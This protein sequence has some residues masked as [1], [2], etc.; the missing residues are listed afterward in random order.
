MG[1]QDLWESWEPPYD[2]I[3]AIS[4]PVRHPTAPYP[5]LVRDTEYEDDLGLWE[6]PAE[7]GP[8]GGPHYPDYPGPRRRAQHA[9]NPGRPRLNGAFLALAGA[10]AIA[11]AIP[12]GI[13]GVRTLA[14]HGNPALKTAPLSASHAAASAPGPNGGGTF[15][16]LAGP[17]CPVAANA[18]TFPYHAPNGDGWHAGTGAGSGPCGSSFIYSY[19]AMVPGNPGEWHD[20][21]AWVFRT[22]MDN[23]SC[24]FSLYIP[25]APQA[26]ST[27]YYWFSAGDSNAVNR[28][29][30]FTIDQAAHQG[31]W[32]TKGP[33]TFLGGTVLIEATDRGEGAPTASVAVGPVRLSC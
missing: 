28:I 31:Q 15:T 26:N 13:L 6:T 16:A 32:V 11:G 30:D 24:T 10:L 2:P 21:Y 23:P 1:F 18:S 25:A 5:E 29:A 12:L 14:H 22:G 4:E 33:F 9:R 3:G 20:H 17:G 7:A 19:L 8:G 27:D